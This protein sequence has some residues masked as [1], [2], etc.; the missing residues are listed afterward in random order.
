MMVH[1]LQYTDEL[2]PLYAQ[3]RNMHFVAKL[4]HQIKECQVAQVDGDW[5]SSLFEIL[6]QCHHNGKLRDACLDPSVISLV[7]DIALDKSPSVLNCECES[8]SELEPPS[9][10]RSVSSEPR[11]RRPCWH[12]FV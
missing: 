1:L 4:A 5:L 6:V 12:L 10:A 9:T 7:T 3:L 2:K 8:L 11:Y